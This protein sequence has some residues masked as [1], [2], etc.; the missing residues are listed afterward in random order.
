MMKRLTNAE[1]FGISAKIIRQPDAVK[2]VKSGDHECG[3][4][5]NEIHDGIIGARFFLLYF[6]I[7]RMKLI[8]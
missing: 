8:N 1:Q 7:L 6:K 4:K 5:P 3:S 2:Q